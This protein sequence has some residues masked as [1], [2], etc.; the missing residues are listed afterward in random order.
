[1]RITFRVQVFLP[2]CLLCVGLFFVEQDAATVLNPLVDVR[3]YAREAVDV[4]TLPYIFSQCQNG[5]AK[6]STGVTLP[7]LAGHVAKHPGETFGN[8]RHD[9]LCPDETGKSILSGVVNGV[10]P[11]YK[12]RNAEKRRIWT[13]RGTQRPP[14]TQKNSYIGLVWPMRHD[15]RDAFRMVYTE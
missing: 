11:K 13:L 10:K 7:R 3:G 8:R 12:G 4:R 1:M 9:A 14:E 6:W 5:F 2:H 15:R